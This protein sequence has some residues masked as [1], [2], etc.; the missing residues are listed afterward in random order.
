MIGTGTVPTNSAIG[1]TSGP[2]NNLQA[3]VN[4]VLADQAGSSVF[5][6]DNLGGQWGTP[7]TLGQGAD[8]VY[9]VNHING[10]APGSA[11][12]LYLVTSTS[13]GNGTAARVF[14]AV[15]VILEANGDLHAVASNPAPVPLPAAAWLLG[16][17]LIGLAGIG[18]R[19]RGT[20]A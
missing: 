11:Q 17:G 15:S 10:A 3:A 18:R 12:A 5:G 16:S 7:S 9:D 13:G 19:R 8:Q 14:Q 2:I 6:T 4:E 20:Q 1:T